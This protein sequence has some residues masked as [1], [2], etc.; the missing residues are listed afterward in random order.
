MATSSSV[1]IRPSGVASMTSVRASRPSGRVDLG[2][3]QAG[4]TALTR[5]PSARPRAPGPGSARR[6]RPW[7]RRSAR[8]CR[9]CPPALPAIEAVLTIR[10]GR[11]AWSHPPAPPARAEE[12]ALQ[13]GV[14]AA[15]Q[16]ASDVARR[17]RSGPRMPALLSSD[18]G[19]PSGVD[20]LEQ[21]PRRGRWRRRRWITAIA[22]TPCPH[23]SAAS[24]SPAWSRVVDR[25]VVAL[26]RR[27]AARSRRRCRREPPVTITLLPLTSRLAPFTLPRAAGGWSAG[28]RAAPA[29]TRRA[30]P[31]AARSR[32]RSRLVG[33][34]QALDHLG[35]DPQAFEVVH[36]ALR[37]RA[38]VLQKVAQAAGAAGQVVGRVRPHDRPAQPRPVGD[39]ADRRPPGWRRPASTRLIASR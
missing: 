38:D 5:I 15:A 37:G 7:M 39:A 31:R 6:P 19:R 2:V 22:R 12:A 28:S 1:P 10:P 32:R 29:A 23:G 4:A 14:H 20:R 34:D 16:S 36:P 8:R 13:V 17:R 33:S 27:T 24:A 25:D 21:A 18:V 11:R 26:R 9:R 30:R 35:R 3:D